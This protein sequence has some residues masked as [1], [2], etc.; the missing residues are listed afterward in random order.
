MYF[1]G[2]PLTTTTRKKKTLAKL[3]WA[4]KRIEDILAGQDVTL[5]DIQLP[6]ERDPSETE[7]ERFQKFKALL[8]E[9]LGEIN[10]GEPRLCRACQQPLP[11]DV[12]DDMPWAFRCRSCP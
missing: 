6:H 11:E 2:D 9:T 4:C 1:D 10:R 7:L 8:N 12:L 5:T 3:G